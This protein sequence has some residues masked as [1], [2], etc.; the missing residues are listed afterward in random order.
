MFQYEVTCWL[1]LQ[2][3]HYL[4]YCVNVFPINNKLDL[5]WYEGIDYMRQMRLPEGMWICHIYIYLADILHTHTYIYMYIFICMYVQIVISPAIYFPPTSSRLHHWQAN[6]MTYCPWRI[7]GDLSTFIDIKHSS[8]AA[9][10]LHH[11][12]DF[13]WPADIS[14]HYAD[15][16]LLI[17]SHE[18]YRATNM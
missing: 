12:D 4:R 15:L 17:M 16:T 8:Y 10:S 1:F 13:W 6:I 9:I 14:S 2:K 7:H 11:H 3:I 18:S 5:I